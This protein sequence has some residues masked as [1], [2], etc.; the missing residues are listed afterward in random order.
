M[1]DDAGSRST[2]A[3]L[4]QNRTASTQFLKANNITDEQHK[5][6]SLK[7]WLYSLSHTDSDAKAS[8][9]F[10]WLS[11]QHGPSDFTSESA[12][13]SEPASN[14]RVGKGITL[15]CDKSLAE[16]GPAELRCH[17]H[18]FGV[19]EEE[20]AAYSAKDV[21]LYDGFTI[22]ELL[23]PVD[24]P[25]LESDLLEIPEDI[26][27]Y[28]DDI[29]RRIEEGEKLGLSPQEIPV[30][31]SA[32]TKSANNPTLTVNTHK[33]SRLSLGSQPQLGLASR[34]ASALPSPANK[35]ASLP[36]RFVPPV[37]P[38]GNS[39]KGSFVSRLPRRI[40]SVRSSITGS[41]PSV[42]DTQISEK[43][44]TSRSSSRPLG[45]PPPRTSP[46]EPTYTLNGKTFT[47]RIPRPSASLPKRSSILN[48]SDLSQ[49]VDSSDLSFSSDSPAPNCRRPYEPN[50]PS[51]SRLP[52]LTLTRAAS[53]S[54]RSDSIRG[55]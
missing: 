52:R 54:S 40:S 49:T 30:H 6:N 46:T 9:L 55:L 27:K 19:T 14:E 39:T 50:S 1:S 23:E 53:N 28:L 10:S 18:L 31:L 15:S 3:S 22:E 11:S 34:E 32:S 36:P 24:M 51:A 8:L 41:S 20:A 17:F 35:K 2:G 44:V 26:Q 4:V 47:S 5:R 43:G 21:C 37:S 38:Y 48:G 42:A 13:V 45:V 12:S 29:T 16:E 33:Q 25:P 7:E